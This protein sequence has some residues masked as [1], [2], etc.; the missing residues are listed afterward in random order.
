MKQLGDHSKTQ[1]EMVFKQG[2]KVD[3]IENQIVE[4]KQNMDHAV[5]DMK[6]A[7]EL[8]KSS[9]GMLNKVFYIIV[10]VVLLLILLSWM[11]P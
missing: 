6:E 4:A 5:I 2:E 8:N 1:A 9:G 11:M 3:S 7:N 10:I